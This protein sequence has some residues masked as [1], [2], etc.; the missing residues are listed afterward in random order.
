[1]RALRSS[2]EH[3]AGWREVPTMAPEGLISPTL[4]VYYYA[5][6]NWGGIDTTNRI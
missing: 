2:W 3:G 5:E 6:N 1:M 4:F